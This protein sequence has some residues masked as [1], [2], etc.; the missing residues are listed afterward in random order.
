[1]SVRREDETSLRS[2]YALHLELGLLLSLAVLVVAVNVDLSTDRSFNVRM[3]EQETVEMRE[4]RQTEQETEPPPP[5]R[6]PVPM[7][8][9]NDQVVEQE[10]VNFD[11]SLDM[12]E[13]LNTEQGPPAPSEDEEDGEQQEG[14]IFIAVEEKPELIGG[15]AALQEAVDYPPMAENAGIE[16]RVIVQFVVNENGDVEDPTVIRGVHRLLDKAAIEAVRAQEFTP[17]KQRGQPVKVQM[18]LPVAFTLKEE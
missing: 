1:M 10:D 16:G 11:A 13:R 17:G 6:P 7:E 15:M 4:I 12:D 8:V 18:S 9:P 2:E 5:P 14:E 3:E